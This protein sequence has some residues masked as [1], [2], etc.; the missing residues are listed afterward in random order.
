[1]QLKVDFGTTSTNDQ[2]FNFTL[3]GKLIVES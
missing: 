1:M 2:V 3:N